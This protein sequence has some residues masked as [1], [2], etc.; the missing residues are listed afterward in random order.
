[1]AHALLGASSSHRWLH[2]TPSARLEETVPNVSSEY[3]NEGTLAHARGAYRLKR[4]LGLDTSAEEREMAE[5]A[6]Y[7]TD[8]MDAHVQ[9]YVDLSWKAYQAALRR[10]ESNPGSVRPELHIEQHLDYGLWVPE[11]FG[12]GDTCVVGGGKLVIIDLKY[13]KGVK[14]MAQ[15]NPQLKLYALGAMDL[16]D[17]AY[18]FREVVLTICQPRLCHTDH[19][20]ISAQALREWAD[21]ELRRRAQLAWEGKG[22]RVSGSWCRFC[23]VK[24]GCPAQAAL[25]FGDLEF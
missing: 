21:G 13:G 15:D 11:G 6:A 10:W 19:W 8:E 5:F 23:R 17:Y 14:V 25:L 20:V 24:Q 7:A 22:E 9:T 2:C 16:Y 1:M 12:T 18:D 3:A 4:L